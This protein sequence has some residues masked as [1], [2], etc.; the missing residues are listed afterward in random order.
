MPYV[1]AER[2]V[3]AGWIAAVRAKV[4]AGG[5]AAAFRGPLDRVWA[6]LRAHPGLRT[7]GHNLF[8]YHHVGGD[9]LTVDFGVEVTRAFEGE[10]D[11][12][13]VATPAGRVAETLHRGDYARL[14]E[15][16][17][18]VWAWFGRSGRAMGAASWERYGDW[19]DDPA[20]LE[21]SVAYLIR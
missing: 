9:D 13:C 1:I 12:R 10:G 15:A 21:T 17:A 4:P 7:D 16:H 6:F 18:A 19:S 2:E 3:E 14:G 5:V 11:V 20:K 8:L